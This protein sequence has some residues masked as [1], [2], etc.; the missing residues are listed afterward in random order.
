LTPTWRNGRVGADYISKR[1][2]RFLISEHL[3]SLE[4]RY[5]TWVNLPFLSDHAPII[6]HLDATTHKTTYPYKFNSNWLL[7]AEF[8]SLVAEIWKD[9]LYLSE[10]CIQHRIVWK[11]RILKARTKAWAT[12]HQKQ[13]AQRLFDLDSAIRTLILLDASAGYTGANCF[14]LQELESE[15]NQLLIKEESTWRQRCRTNWIKSGD[16]NTKFFHKFASAS[17]N[18]KHIWG[19]LSEDGILH[20][21][22]QP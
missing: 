4:E 7:E 16:L 18:K 20:K 10:Q 12:T 21:G 17:R 3:L 8:N 2:D 15:Q 14:S 1:L 11:L 9:P 22:Q 13:N 6:L 19:I 5:R